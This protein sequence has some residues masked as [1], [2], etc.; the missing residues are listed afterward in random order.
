M[1]FGKS[2]D[3]EIMKVFTKHIANTYVCAQ[4][5][6]K[7]CEESDTNTN[8]YL[9]QSIL[10]K[11]HEGDKLTNDVHLLLEN[12]F[13]TK[14]D[15]DDIV[16]LADYLDDIIDKMKI[17]ARL[18]HAYRVGEVRLEAKELSRVILR[19]LDIL[20]PLIR[21][22]AGQ[23]MDTLKEAIY[24]IK[25]LEEEADVILYKGLG[26]LHLNENDFKLILEWRD[27]LRALEETTDYCDRVCGVVSSIVR[28][29][30]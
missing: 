9:I 1:F 17:V 30:R 6:V 22:M 23:N 27:I 21:E 18:F 28:K 24:K 2:K 13:I 5:L 25:G 3:D 10:E 14:I 15:K 19:M 16:K 26:A 8:S 29:S 7:L 12:A 11:E 4:E 20:E